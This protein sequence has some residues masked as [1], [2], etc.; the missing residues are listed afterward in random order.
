MVVTNDDALAEQMRILRVHG[1]KKKYVHEMVGGNFRLDTLQ[2]AVLSVKIQYLDQWN[3]ARRQRAAEYRRLIAASSVASRV[4]TPVE[5]PRRDHIYNQ[6]II[7]TARRDRVLD[8]FRRLNIGTAVYYPIAMHMQECFRDLGYTPGS[9][10]QSE[11]ACLETCALP[12][13]PEL[14]RE[15]QSVVVDA[16]TEA[17]A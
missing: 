10:P 15:Q 3:A 14:T 11:Q 17:L 5:L 8:V 12:M 6:F 16:L 13:F 9:F 4:N 1:A 2:A 7:R